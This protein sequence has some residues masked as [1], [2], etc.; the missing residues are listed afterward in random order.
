MAILAVSALLLGSAASTVGLAPASATVTTLCSGYTA[1]YK[2]GMSASGYVKARDTMW[3]RM[4]AGHNCTNYA[5]YRMV[6]S[7]LPNVRPWD[8]GGNATYWGTK[9]SNIT[10]QTPAVGAVAWWKAGVSPAG[11]SGHVAYVERVVSADEIIISQDSWGGDFSWAR[12]TRASRG[13][14]SGFVHFNDVP[15]LNVVKPEINGTAKVGDLLAAS[16]GTWKP[17]DPALRYQWRAGGS[18]ITGATASTLTLTK[19]QLDKTISVRVWASKLGYPTTSV[20]SA[21]TA[22]VLPGVLSNTVAPRVTGK[23]VVDSVLSASGGTWFPAPD[24]LKYQWQADGVSIPGADGSTLAIGPD[25]VGKVLRLNV[26]ASRAGYD[27]VTASS[28]ATKA[29]EPGTLTVTR[30]PTT[31]GEPRPGQTLTLEPM[32]V[33]PR[34]DVSVQWLR[35]GVPVEGATGTTYRLTAADLGS[36]VTARVRATRPGYTTITTRTPATARVRSVPRIKVSLT[37]RRHGRVTVN[38]SVTARGV[39]PVEGTL[40]IRSRGRVLREVPLIDGTA[41]TRLVGLRPGMWTLRIVLPRSATVSKGLV[42][43]R[44]TIR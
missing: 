12:I 21:P 30:Q 10:D 40:L 34:A 39:N 35:A 3:W 20:L 14:P 11:S 16:P 37:P 28:A 13:W 23:A 2:A 1:C 7:G 24:A 33:S 36:R 6:R 41:R 5:A 32:R 27:D 18:R 9:M 25:L 8:G 26:T 19:A 15:L 22:A 42:I 43:R 44:V 4:Y 17:G 31:T 38:G 29:V